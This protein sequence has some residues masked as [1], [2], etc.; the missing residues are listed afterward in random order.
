MINM[1]ILV[2]DDEA[3]IRKTTAMTLDALGH[4]CVQAQNGAEALTHLQKGSFDAAFLDLRLGNEDGLDLIP[5]LVAL[6]PKLA[7]IVFTAY[8]SIDTAV[9]AMRRGAVD[10]IAKPFTPDQ[11]RQSLGRIENARRLENRVVEIESLLSDTQTLADFTSEEPL[12][13][14]LF[15]TANKAAASAAT[16]LLLGESGTGKSVLARALH[17]NSRSARQR[18]RHRRL[19]EPF[20]RTSGERAFRP[21]PGCVHRRRRG[22]VGQ[23]QGGR[24]RYAF[25]R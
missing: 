15:E 13:Q 16:L 1:R 7:V 25:S 8:S 4:E 20:P 9:E 17:G 23:G 3:H 10:Y 2:I 14:K 11:I 12:V 19:P 18:L 6:E 21:R 22:N 24:G 5:K